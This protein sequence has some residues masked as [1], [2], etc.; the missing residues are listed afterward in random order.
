MS[1]GILSRGIMS[2]IRVGSG[3]VR[4]DFF[5]FLWVGL[6]QSTPRV[7]QKSK[8]LRGYRNFHQI[9]T[10][11]QTYFTRTLHTSNINASLHYLVKY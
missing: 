4:S 8:P 6:G 7:M 9:F 5:N 11:F 1:G 3:G 2:W 10:N